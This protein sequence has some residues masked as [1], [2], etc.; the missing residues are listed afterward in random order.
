MT[1]MNLSMKQKQTHEQREQTVAAM[2]DGVGG[3]IDWETGV[4]RFKLLYIEWINKQVLLYSQGTIFSIL[5][6]IIMEN[7]IFL[8]QECVYMYNQTTF[9]YSRN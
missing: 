5:W 1:Q 7:N 4:S 6:Q 9:L 2:V 8:K 3:R